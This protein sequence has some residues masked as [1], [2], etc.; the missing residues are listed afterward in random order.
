VQTGNN[1]LIGGF[2]ITGSTPKQV[3]VRAIG[4]SLGAFG[5]PDPLADPTLELRSS[6]GALIMQNDN[7]QDDPMQ[8]TQLTALGLAPT[9]VHESG[10]VTT[11]DPN[12]SY[13]AIVAGRNGGTGVGLV[14]AYDT[15]G[16]TNSELANISTRGFVETGANVMIGGFILGGTSSAQVAVRGIGPSLS[17]F[18][19]PALADPTLEL[20]NS[21]GA[22][23]AMNDNW[24]DD[25]A[26]AAQL[27]AHGLAPTNALESGIFASLAPGA[28]TAILAGRNGG[29]GIG[30]VEVYN[31]P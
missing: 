26:S 1:V 29:T 28:Y 4:P 19:N 6:T 18:V 9:D 24:Q 10:L 25:P 8:A 27:S 11:L 16:A 7:W 14:E 30:L 21:N 13:T 23:L 3:A 2:I 20:H 12:T 22:T 31:V 17:Q 5:I 15:N